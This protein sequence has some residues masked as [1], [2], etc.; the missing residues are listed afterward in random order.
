MLVLARV[1]GA[2]RCS[3]ELPDGRRLTLPMRLVTELQRMT[4]QEAMA[5]LEPMLQRAQERDAAEG[6][7][8][9]DQSTEEPELEAPD[10]A[11]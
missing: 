10:A 4:P 9:G 5:L 11:E 6:V 2:G 1:E 8:E 7:Q 3:Q